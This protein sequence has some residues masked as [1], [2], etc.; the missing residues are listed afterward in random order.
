MHLR[1]VAREHG[2]MQAPEVD[3]DA[4]QLVEGAL[5]IDLLNVYRCARRLLSPETEA[6]VQ[7][8]ALSGIGDDSIP[9]AP[10]E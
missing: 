8:P 5:R 7:T 4:H 9:L 6:V 2:V 10:L 1:R 3:G